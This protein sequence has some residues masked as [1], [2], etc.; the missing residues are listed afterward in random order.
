MGKVKVNA[1][2]VNE[3]WLN[4][5]QF[6]AFDI[7]KLFSQINFKANVDQTGLV[8]NVINLS[9]QPVQL[10]GDN[11]PTTNI[12][13]K[14]NEFALLN[15]AANKYTLFISNKGNRPLKIIESVDC[16]LS[17][18]ISQFSFAAHDLQI[19]APFNKIYD[20]ELNGTFIIFNP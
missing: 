5:E 3:L 19:S 9:T 8:L 17:N 10:Y 20:S 2:N 12:A 7:T 13:A 6:L 1:D 16:I 14:S 4:N 15:V 18:D 11:I